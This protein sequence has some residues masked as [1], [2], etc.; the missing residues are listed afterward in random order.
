MQRSD[1][2]PGTPA[3]DHD[4]RAVPGGSAGGA[5]RPRRGSGRSL[6]GDTGGYS[7]RGLD[8]TTDRGRRA[9]GRGGSP[10][11]GGYP[12]PHGPE[13]VRWALD[14]RAGVC[15]NNTV[16]PP[17]PPRGGC[18]RG[19]GGCRSGSSSFSFRS[20][21]SLPEN[22]YSFHSQRQDVR[23]L[24]LSVSDNTPVA[25]SFHYA[26]LGVCLSNAFSR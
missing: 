14:K 8:R 5:G 7:K 17:T 24:T 10:A 18:A 13:E 12:W 15:E 6:S 19:P 20:R 2:G 21:G 25:S 3:G 26:S 16:K 4:S 9:A 1:T 23:V 22:R 11:S